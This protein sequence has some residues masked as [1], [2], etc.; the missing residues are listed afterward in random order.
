V[1]VVSGASGQLGGL[2]ARELLERVEPE[3]LRLVTRDP[4]RLRDIPPA[5]EVARADFDE[6]ATLPAAFA[7]GST[8]MLV[9]TDTITDRAAQHARAIDAA[10]NAGIRRVVYTSMISPGEENPALI[11][12]SHR[13]TEE[14]LRASGMEWTILRCGF[15]ADFQAFEAADALGS[16]ELVHNRGDGRCAY[17]ARADIARSAAAVLAEDG[18]EGAVYELTGPEALSADELADLY[19][20]VG[21]SPVETIGLDDDAYLAVIG[22]S[23]DGHVQYGVALAV[24]LGQAMRLGLHE[25]VSGDVERLTGRAPQSVAD[26]LQTQAGS[27]RAV[28]RQD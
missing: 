8:L 12:D 11:A 24:S 23:A 14:Q 22:G 25:D 7:G 17:V 20:R 6:P 15:Y 5:V 13:A 9:S 21:D 28:A 18:H 26:L 10:R 2:I 1:I 4:D 27:L 3:R 19:S 16:G